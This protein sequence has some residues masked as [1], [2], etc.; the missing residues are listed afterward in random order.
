MQYDQTI[1]ARRIDP[2]SY[3]DIFMII[4]QDIP[5]GKWF[6]CREL[7]YEVLDVTFTR[8]TVVVKALKV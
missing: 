5:F 3:D 7:G 8:K 6:R 1:T 4:T 2:T